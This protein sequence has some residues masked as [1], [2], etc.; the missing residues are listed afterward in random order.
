MTTRKYYRRK[1]KKSCR[2][3]HSGHKHSG[4]KRSNIYKILGSSSRN[5]GQ[6]G[7]NLRNWINPPHK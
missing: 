7:G 3:R 4:H 6:Q 2:I 5:R 1:C